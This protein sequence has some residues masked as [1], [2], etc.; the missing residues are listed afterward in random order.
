MPKLEV[1]VSIKNGFTIYTFGICFRSMY[2]MSGR[3]IQFIK[4]R[5]F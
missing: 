2:Q 5:D 4:N 1:F 3:G